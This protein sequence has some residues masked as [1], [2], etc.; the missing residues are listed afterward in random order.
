VPNALAAAAAALAAG[1]P[2]A[3]VPRGLAAYRPVPGRL[4]PT[5]LAGGG[6]L[7][8]DSYNANPQSL[9]VA[10]RALVRGESKGR[11][12][13]VLG[14][15]G[16]LG[17]YGAEAHREAGELAARLGVDRIFALGA[18]AAEIV[19][20]AREA[21]MEPDALHAGEDWEE[22]ARRVLD[23]IGD[24]DRILVKGSRSMRMERI[25]LHLRRGAGESA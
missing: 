17:E 21:G 8:D 7:I 9:E 15:M 16:E 25:A 19:G 24:G 10:L 14:D 1:A 18:H 11:R 2:L 13:A 20:A 23:A 3:D 4:D 12:I 22:T 6:L 5:P